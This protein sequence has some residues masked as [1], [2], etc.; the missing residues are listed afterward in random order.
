[1]VFFKPR[2][3]FVLLSL[4]TMAVFNLKS[5]DIDIELYE[6]CKAIDAI[7]KTVHQEDPSFFS[8]LKAVLFE[9]ADKI[10]NDFKFF[11]SKEGIHSFIDRSTA[12][13]GTIAAFAAYM[14]FLIYVQM[15]AI[16]ANMEQEGLQI[17]Y[18]GQID[19][20]LSGVAGMSGPKA[21][22]QD[23]ISY[24]KNPKMYKNI[25][26]HVP[27]GI[28]LNGSPGNGKTLLA[29]AVAGE[30]SCPF[31]SINGSS[32]IQMY[33]G[34][35]A[36]RVRSLFAKAR[37]LASK[38]GACIIF[39]DEIDA[40]ALQ[41]SSSGGNGEHDQ[42]INALLAEMDGLDKSEYPVI[43]LGATNRAHL[44]DAAIVR[45]GRF[46]RTV[47]VSKLAIK[48]R[49]ELL[50]IAV[51]SVKTAVEFDVN[52]IA[53]MTIN[54]SGA[55][56][57]NLVNEAA[58][59]A[60][61]AGRQV[62]VMQ[63]VELAFD[64]ITL[65]REITGMQQSHDK[66]W[67]TAIHEAGHTMAEILCDKAHI[68]HKVSITPRS[69]TLGVMRMLPLYESYEYT[70]DDMKNQIVIVLCGRLA[71]EAFGMG[72]STGASNDL[73]KAH[74][75]AYDMVA[76]YG[77]SDT[78]RNIGFNRSH[79]MPNDIATQ[80]E[81]EVQAIINECAERGKQLM[82]E[83]KHDIESIAKLL[84]EK[85]TVLGSDIYELLNLDMPAP[86]AVN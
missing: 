43:V 32:F 20:N 27:K 24:I 48:D 2:K 65:G 68:V 33:V 1:M 15:K 51:K 80:I 62:V 5:I 49:I 13:I 53:Q 23:I 42:T 46:D 31:I 55:E 56:L 19:F 12:T 36:M 45:P 18:P 21:D 41:R 26:A 60:V 38:Y 78:L 10:E 72:L 16:D 74:A 69:N 28:L 67:K 71:E 59:L 37:N 40:V 64:H 44:L 77:M 30:V 29:K 35:G 75:L 70:Q 50:Q 84:I 25:G 8:N 57:A 81:R 83:H 47:E 4:L 3:N 86:C 66:K 22:M 52:R 7:K 9:K 63:D 34:V 14:Y 17:Y 85:G 58:I 6:A 61:N 39:I 79:Q 76:V 11:Q 82:N 54:F 73:E